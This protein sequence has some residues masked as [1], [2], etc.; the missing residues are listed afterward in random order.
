MIYM[1]HYLDNGPTEIARTSLTRADNDMVRCPSTPTR[2]PTHDS[3]RTPRASV[4]AFDRTPRQTRPRSP[5][6]ENESPERRI[7]GFTLSHLRRVPELS[8][9]ARR[10]VH[11]EAKRRAKEASREERTKRMETP[12]MQAKGENMNTKTRRL[13]LWAIRRLREEGSIVIWDGPVQVFSTSS[14]EGSWTLWN[15]GSGGVV[16]LQ[17]EDLDA[18][19]SD[20]PDDEEAYVSL[21]PRYIADH[22][23]DIIR[24]HE[25]ATKGEITKYLRRDDRW[26]RV[27]EWTVEETLALLKQE[28][29][30]WEVAQGRW[31]VCL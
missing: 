15:R 12:R 22:I 29:R 24:T 7:G 26:A 3:G 20:P 21:T 8:S 14:E 19:L 30:V 16:D 18:E 6:I 11:A 28:G 23:E 27:G 25:G 4:L 9:L 13:F 2:R 5:K 17:E 1:K 31:E 10:V